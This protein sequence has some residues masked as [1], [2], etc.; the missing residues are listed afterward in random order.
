MHAMLMLIYSAMFHLVGAVLPIL[1]RLIPS[2]GREI[3]SRPPVE[4]LAAKWA[5]A[6][7]SHRTCVLFFCS[8]AGEYEQARPIIDRLR[9][10]PK[11]PLVQVLL[12]SRSGMEYVKARGEESATIHL[13]PLTDSVWHWGWLFS[14]LR[15]DIIAVVRHELWP[16]FIDT[17][18]SYSHLCLIAASRSLGELRGRGK[19]LAR[20][21][22]LRGFHR[23][24]TVAEADRDFFYRSYQVPL[25][26]MTTVGDPKFDRVFERAARKTGK[27]AAELYEVF[28]LAAKPSR[29]RRLVLGSTYIQDIAV[30]MQ[31]YHALGALTEQWQVIIA[32]HHV[33]MGTCENIMQI[34]KGGGIKFIKYSQLQS[35]SSRGPSDWPVIVLDTM[36]MLAEVYGVA[37]MA[38]V[39]GALHRQVHNVLEPACLGL[40]VGFGPHHANSQE[41]LQLVDGGLATVIASGDEFCQWWQSLVEGVSTAEKHRR[42]TAVSQLRGAS[43]R[44]VQEW[45]PRL[46]SKP[47]GRGDDV[48]KTADYK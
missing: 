48:R 8:S 24:Y 35:D 29:Q 47:G 2:W 36:G 32:P 46:Q 15:P 31:A 39:G 41:A 7:A 1:S 18:R 9:A 12:F 13:C 33:D 17:A 45:L 5:R 11:P 21:Q 37:D 26:A 4:V 16:G 19:R 14:A 3:S 43:D 30:W 10:E 27:A 22:L 40:A 28:R 44:I 6:R 20:R 34:M 23:I 42:I 25:A 38:F